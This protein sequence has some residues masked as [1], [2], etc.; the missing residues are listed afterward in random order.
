MYILEV[1]SFQSQ[2]FTQCKPNA[3]VTRS[4]LIRFKKKKIMKK[5][6]SVEKLSR[7]KRISHTCVHFELKEQD[8][9]IFNTGVFQDII[10]ITPLCHH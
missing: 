9:K 1:Q 3:P 4:S 2:I 8:A 6:L 10:Y 7:G 5:M